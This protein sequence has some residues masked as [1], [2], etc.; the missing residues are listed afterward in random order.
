MRPILFIDGYKLDHRRQYPEGTTRV[1]SNWTPRSSRIPDQLE[2]VTFGLQYFL[3]R[4]MSEAMGRWFFERPAGEV[5]DQY[6][7]RVAGYVGPNDIGTDHI[8]ELHALGYV[9]LEFRALPEGTLCPLRV[10]MLTVENTHDRFAWLVNYIETWM[11]N[12][13]WL[14]ATSAT[15]AYRFRKMLNAAAAETGGEADFVPW[16]GHDF[17][18]RGMAGIEAAQMSGAGHLLSFTGTDTLPAL[19]FIERYYPGENGLVGGSVPATEHSVMSAG[20]AEDEAETFARILRLYPEGVVSVVS[21]TWDLWHVLT[22]ILPAMQSQIRGRSGKLVIRPDSGDPVKIVCGDPEATGPAHKGVVELLWDTFGGTQ[23]QT[24]H[25]QLDPHVGV[26]YGDAITY[27]RGRAICEG[28]RAK[29]FASTNVVFGVGSFS[30]HFCT[31][32]TYGFAMKATWA[33]VQ[34]EGRDLFKKPATDDGAKFSAKGRLAVMT[35]RRGSLYVAQGTSPDMEARS[36]LQPVWRDGK[37]I[38]RQSFAE[39]R[40]TLWPLALRIP[41]PRESAPDEGSARLAPALGQARE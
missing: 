39:V 31:R 32:D 9:P 23:T 36:L 34:G 21:D 35:S 12:V 4:Y 1:Y 41:D 10:P 15:T 38:R 6:A 27:D 22:S 24:G 3:E 37:F 28:L 2:V 5:C 8:A 11:S 18:M 7:A 13:L 20:G 17:S 33:K 19:D 25:R 30:Y 40:K 29:G 14:P 26:I 16:Q